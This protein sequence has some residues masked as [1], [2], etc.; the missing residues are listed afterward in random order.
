MTRNRL[1]AVRP[2]LSLRK[3][4]DDVCELTGIEE[5]T[6]IKDLL[7]HALNNPPESL[8]R[9]MEVQRAIRSREAVPA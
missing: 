8:A 6:L 3:Q 2:S 1:I 7:Q 9:L 5:P 4:I